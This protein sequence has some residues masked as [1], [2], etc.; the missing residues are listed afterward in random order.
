MIKLN[1]N[2]INPTIFPDGTSQVWKIDLPEKEAKIVWYYENEVELIHLNQ[3]I[4]LLENTIG[5]IDELYV[6]Y[7]PYA[8]QDKQISNTS[9]FAKH[10]F[11][12][13]L[14]TTH[15]K[16]LITLDVHSNVLMGQWEN[17]F[18]EKHINYVIK[19]YGGKL[20]VIVYPDVGAYERY[21][22]KLN[23]DCL[24]LQKERDQLTGEILGLTHQNTIQHMDEYNFLIIDDICDGGRTFI[25]ATKY[26][27]T[28]YNNATVDLYVTHGIF[29]KGLQ[30]LQE[31]G[32]GEIFTTDSLQEFRFNKFQDFSLLNIV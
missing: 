24:V 4:S 9:T 19:S 25:E 3:L 20:P 30:P 18:P 32:I 1:G 26:I 10:T 22:T 2:I 12:N 21:H 11:L 17:V 6:P 31:S 7:L 8:R 28:I 13:M 14:D 15:I 23:L 5:Y 29:S 16:K 27:K